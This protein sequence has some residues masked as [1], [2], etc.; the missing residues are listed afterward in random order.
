VIRKLGL[1]VNVGMRLGVSGQS[2]KSMLGL[3][4]C[5]LVNSL[6]SSVKIVAWKLSIEGPAGTKK[7][8]Q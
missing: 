5:M 4:D 6:D 2:V 8:L 7:L 1:I 3:A